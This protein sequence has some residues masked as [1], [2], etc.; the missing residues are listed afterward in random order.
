M[1]IYND[2]TELVGRTPLVALNRLAEGAKAVENT[3]SF[4]EHGLI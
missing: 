2:I 1:T 4:A 3:Y